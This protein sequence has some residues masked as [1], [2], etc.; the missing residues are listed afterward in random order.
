MK[1]T[2]FSA[3]VRDSAIET[4][5]SNLVMAGY[6]LPGEEAKLMGKLTRM[7]DFELAEQLCASRLLLDQH[8]EICWNLN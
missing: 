6:L 8:L 7:N 4:T 3:T 5:V 1:Q 2:L